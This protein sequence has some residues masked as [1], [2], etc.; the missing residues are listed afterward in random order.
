MQ[1]SLIEKQMLVVSSPAL[2][3]HIL[4]CFR[5]KEKRAKSKTIKKLYHFNTHS[6]NNM[7]QT[8][9]DRKKEEEE[10][11]KIHNN[12]SAIRKYIL[13][14]SPLLEKQKFMNSRKGLFAN[15]EAERNQECE[16]ATTPLILRPSSMVFFPWVRTANIVEK[17]NEEVPN[18]EEVP[19][20]YS[21][22][23]HAC[24]CML[25]AIVFPARMYHASVPPRKG[26]RISLQIQFE[27]GV[28][29]VG[30]RSQGPP[31]DI[32][33]ET[34]AGFVMQMDDPLY[35]LIK[36]NVTNLIENSLRNKGVKDNINMGVVQS[37]VWINM[38]TKRRAGQR[39][40]KVAKTADSTEH[41]WNQ[42]KLSL[43]KFRQKNG[44]KD[45]NKERYLLINVFKNLY[46][47]H[48]HEA[49]K[50]I[51]FLIV[52]PTTSLRIHSDI[53]HILPSTANSLVY[54][55]NVFRS[56]DYLPGVMGEGPWT[57]TTNPR[58]AE[59][60]PFLEKKSLYDGYLGEARI[61]CHCH[62]K[63]NEKDDKKDDKKLTGLVMY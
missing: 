43:E 6:V 55:V 22:S 15:I 2:W 32:P 26:V 52:T 23:G 58:C 40:N 42:A 61:T 4:E 25:Q 41:F 45:P 53:G 60:S 10:N 28:T 57:H 16:N 9:D 59:D 39:K 7:M 21:G 11:K 29:G 31:L 5:I 1:Q 54:H 8:Q 27:A 63:A 50:E 56:D 18:K 24:T 49:L 35:T 13:G 37:P 17:W 34:H 47:V 12:C 30:R 20:H 62:W 44:K 48:N 19:M 14:S 38:T 33:E 46:G 3:V 51:R 36:Q